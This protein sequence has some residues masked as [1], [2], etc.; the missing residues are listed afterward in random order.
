[1]APLAAICARQPFSVISLVAC[2][3]PTSRFL[4][5]RAP[6]GS[7]AAAAGGGDLTQILEGSSS[8]HERH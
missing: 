8:S 2:S 7:S 4:F 1:M 6:L 5:L 3:P